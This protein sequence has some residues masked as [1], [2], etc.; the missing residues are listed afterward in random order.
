MARY[1]G[2]RWDPLGPQTEARMRSHDI[3]CLH[4]M[5][6]TL[7]GTSA[8]FHQNG[9]GGTESHF[10]LGALGEMLQWQDIAFEADANY[11]GNDRV[12]SIETADTGHGFP[13]WSGSD[14]PA[15]TPEQVD[16]IVAWLRWVTSKA[17]HADCPTSWLCHHHGIPRVLVPD[18]GLSRRG[19]A[20]HRQG[21]ESY[22]TPHKPGWLQPGCERWSSSRGKV[23]PGDRRIEQTKTVIIPRLQAGTAAPPAPEPKEIEM[24]IVDTP[25]KPALIVGVGGVKRITGAQR[26]ALRDAGVEP[27]A[28]DADANDALWSLRDPAVVLDLDEPAIASLLAEELKAELGD[29]DAAAVEA[30][31][32]KVFADAGS[33]G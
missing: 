32:R 11:D 21:V 1:S 29:V 8:M 5:V 25:G 6:G 31:V 28:L 18:T 15:W 26:S 12:I 27:K 19:I 3:A 7:A 30:A 14:V 4:T 13:A 33:D 24:F 20:V 9:Y 16:A 17:A 22:P 2:A 10:G 23:C